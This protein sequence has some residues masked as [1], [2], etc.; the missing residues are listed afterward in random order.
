M[1]VAIPFT[2]EMATAGCELTSSPDEKGTCKAIDDIE[3]RLRQGHERMD[4]IEAESRERTSRMEL[5]LDANCADT[6]EVLD[7]L[8]LG[9]SFFRL[10]GYVGGFLKW[11][12]AIAAPV[13]A[14]WYT[15]K[16]GK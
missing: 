14:L 5:K 15:F 12:T 4:S 16:G 9:K 10:A 6:A 11:S 8:R 1:S 3:L 2:V 13:L 7:I